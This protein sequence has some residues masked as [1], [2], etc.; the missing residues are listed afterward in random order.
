MFPLDSPKASVLAGSSPS[1]TRFSSLAAYPKV[2]LMRRE[3]GWLDAYR[4]A[5][6]MAKCRLLVRQDPSSL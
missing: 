5:V 1:F 3:T 4:L 6:P 2:A